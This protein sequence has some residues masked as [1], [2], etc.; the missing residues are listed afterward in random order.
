[1]RLLFWWKCALAL[2]LLPQI[3]SPLA[4]S[5]R[6]DKF[7]SGSISDDTSPLA[8][9]TDELELDPNL[10]EF[11]MDFSGTPPAAMR[12]AAVAVV[13]IHGAIDSMTSVFRYATDEAGRKWSGRDLARSLADTPIVVLLS[14]HSGRN[15][16]DWHSHAPTGLARMVLDF[17]ARA[18]VAPSWV[19]SVR[20]AVLWLPVFVRE[21]DAGASV[22]A[23]VHS[24][25]VRVRDRCPQP[26]EWLAMHT[27]GDPYIKLN[28]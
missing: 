27:Y 21:L 26:S 4:R 3:V 24:A 7:T 13:G 11:D 10:E 16:F 2:A 25:N 28:R 18:V 14:C 23:A 15:D 1:M 6:A 22:C 12:A 17:G 5:A 20:A 9:L 19:L 8:T